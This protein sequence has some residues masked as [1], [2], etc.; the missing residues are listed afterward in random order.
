VSFTALLIY[1]NDIVLAGNDSNEIESVKVQLDHKFSIKNLGH[2]HYF[3]G[4]EI[5]RS[6]SGIVVNQRK[7]YGDC[8]MV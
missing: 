8:S 7:G 5:S 6:S 1:V 3:F 4:L 2:L